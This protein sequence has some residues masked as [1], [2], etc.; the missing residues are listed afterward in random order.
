MGCAVMVGRTIT[1]SSL[2]P[3]LRNNDLYDKFFIRGR[4]FSEMRGSP[5]PPAPDHCGKVTSAHISV[6]CGC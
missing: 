6:L 1:Q 3:Y 2:I 5:L 4:A